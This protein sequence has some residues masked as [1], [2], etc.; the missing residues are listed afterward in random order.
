MHARENALNDWV[1][2]ALNNPHVIITPLTGDASFRRYWRAISEGQSYILMDAPPEKE[3]ISAFIHIDEALRAINVHAPKIHAYHEPEGFMILED[4]GDEVLL[5]T[6]S[7]QNV[8]ARYIEAMQTL[9]IIQTCKPHHYTLPLFDNQHMMQEMSLFREWFWTTYL[10]LT[11][12]AQESE[13][14]ENAFQWLGQELSQ[15]PQVFI[16]RD[17][18]SR[19]LMCI[20]GSKTNTLGVLDFQD[21]MLGPIG[22][23]LVSLLRDC[24]IAWPEEQVEHWLSYFYHLSSPPG[25]NALQFMRAFDLCGIQRHLKVLGI[26]SRLYLRDGK[27]GYLKDLPLT[28]Q[29]MLSALK[30]YPELA[31]FYELVQSKVRLP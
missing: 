10:K 18:H 27:A 9:A 14:I 19:N 28:L 1:G 6:L 25:I 2:T 23:D 26:F 30:K 24:Y 31:P 29:Y 12:N 15:L 22:Y 13:C 17:Y 3:S 16:H 21:A 5:N 4:F 20:H 8:D 7:V 11:L